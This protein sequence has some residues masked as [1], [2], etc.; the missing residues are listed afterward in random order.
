[1]PN[2]ALQSGGNKLTTQA[3]SDDMKAVIEI[4]KRFLF[5]IICG[6]CAVAGIVMIYMGYSGMSSIEADMQAARNVQTELKTMASSKNLINKD[7]VDQA[8]RRIDQ[9]L[10]AD[11]EIMAT[12]RRIN[13]YKPLTETAF[14]A[15]SPTDKDVFKRAYQSEVDSWLDALNAGDVPTA[16]D[17]AQMRDRID[18]EK[19]MREDLGLEAKVGDDDL[20]NQPEVRA[21]INKAE[22]IFCYATQDSFHQSDVS[23]QDQNAP[24]YADRP[25]TLSQMW[26]AQLE[27]WIQ[28]LIVDGIATINDSAAGE[29]RGN[30]ETP[31]VGNLPIKELVSIQATEYYVTDVGVP[32]NAKA[33]DRRV[34][35]GTAE[36]VFTGNKSNELYE[37]V[38]VTVV[39]VVDAAKIP[40]IVSDLC[41]DRLITP[42][43]V[44]YEVV[45]SNPRM[46]GK[47]F[48]NDPVVRLTIDFEAQFFSELYLPLMPDKILEKL[49]KKRPEAPKTEGA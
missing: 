47:I 17:I 42:L 19:S 31:W 32:K 39:L 12:V 46:E 43:R 13:Y 18:E 15:S 1:M 23:S 41:R 9:V 11:K 20:A 44:E 14:P 34:P 38:Q 26:H 3:W 27:V 24:M 22:S 2:A 45:E 6:V 21:A 48:G 4:I 28:Q 5:E 16:D 7:A 30:N 29:L 8:Q 35:S 49:K 40:G 33:K 25:P 10:A 36:S 37:L